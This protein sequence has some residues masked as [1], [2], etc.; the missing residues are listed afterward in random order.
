MNCVA[1]LPL[2]C[3]RIAVFQKASD[4]Q[5]PQGILCVLSM[6]RY[7]LAERLAGDSDR[8]TDT[9]KAPLYMLLEDL[10]DPGNVGTILRAGE[11]QA[12]TV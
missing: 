4:T 11:G 2:K 3:L 6:P 10:Q 8:D 7:E 9:A 5:T 1:A 12:L